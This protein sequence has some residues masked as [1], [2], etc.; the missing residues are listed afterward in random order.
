MH[1][2]RLQI[3]NRE[4]KY[5]HPRP[6]AIF[7]ILVSS[8][9]DALRFVQTEQTVIELPYDVLRTQE[10]IEEPLFSECPNVRTKN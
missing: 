5:Y 4:D 10:V 7:E 9:A 1:Q 2:N 6:F 3:E 8:S